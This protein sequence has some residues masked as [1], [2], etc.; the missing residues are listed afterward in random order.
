[1]ASRSASESFEG[2]I[3]IGAVILGLLVRVAILLTPVLLVGVPAYIG[4]RVW[5]DSPA[6]AEKIAR[7]E[8]EALYNYAMSGRV[9]LTEAEIQRALTK[10]WP[11]DMPNAL[12]IQLL[13]LG[14]GLLKPRA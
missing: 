11:V 2:R 6:R 1:M 3:V 4:Y 14:R 12:R 5:Y 10:H 13:E 8:T 9:V 7:Q